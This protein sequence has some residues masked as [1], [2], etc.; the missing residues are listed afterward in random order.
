MSDEIRIKNP[1]VMMKQERIDA[2]SETIA[3]LKAYN[4]AHSLGSMMADAVIRD[5][6]ERVAARQATV[7]TAVATEGKAQR[8]GRVF[9][10]QQTQNTKRVSWIRTSAMF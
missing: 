9:N 5:N 6:G 3:A 7:D 4:D 1:E 2:F 8:A 10:Q